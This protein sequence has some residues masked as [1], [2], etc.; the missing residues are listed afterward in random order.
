MAQW[1]NFAPTR[2]PELGLSCMARGL[3]RFVDI[4]DPK[5]RN[6]RPSVVGPQY[7]SKAEALGDLADYHRRNWESE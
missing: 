4:T 3:W 2:F 6:S 7:T 5:T 1:P